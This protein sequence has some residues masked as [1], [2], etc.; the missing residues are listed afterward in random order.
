MANAKYYISK[1]VHRWSVR[2]DGKDYPFDTHSAAVLA[3][4]NAATFASAQGHEAEVL[5]QG[6]DGKWR[7]EWPTA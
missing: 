4:V 7:T 1:D 2:Y 6:I 3:A 5:V